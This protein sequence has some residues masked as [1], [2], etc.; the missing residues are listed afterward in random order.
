MDFSLSLSLKKSIQNY[1]H[2]NTVSTMRF[3]MGHLLKL[4][5][6]ASIDNRPSTDKLQHFVLTKKITCDT[7][8]VTRDMQYVTCNMQLVTCDL[9]YVTRDMLWGVNI[10]SKFQLPSSYCF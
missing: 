2:G 4:Q 9:W 1:L 7:W 8:H 3:N 5:G 10:L 6:V